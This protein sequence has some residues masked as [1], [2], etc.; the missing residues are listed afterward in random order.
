M[1]TG[2]DVVGQVSRRDNLGWYT[3]GALAVDPTVRLE[4]LAPPCVFRLRRSLSLNEHASTL[5]PPTHAWRAYRRAS[6]AEGWVTPCLR[7]RRGGG[8]GGTADR[9]QNVGVAT[10]LR[11]RCLCARPSCTPAHRDPRRSQTTEHL[12]A[13]Q[14]LVRYL[15]A[16]QRLVVPEAAVQL[17]HHTAPMPADCHIV[18]NFGARLAAN[19][20]LAGLQEFGRRWTT[21]ER[22]NRPRMMSQLWRVQFYNMRADDD[23]VH[24]Q[25]PGVSHILLRRVLN[26]G[27][28]CVLR[29]TN[30]YVVDDE[31][32]L[33]TWVATRDRRA[34]I[35]GHLP[36]LRGARLQADRPVTTH[37][38]R[39]AR[40][41]RRR[42]RATR[43]WCAT[44]SG[45]RRRTAFGA[46]TSARRAA[47]CPSR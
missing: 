16:Q 12:E 32:F 44:R 5:P 6:R 11:H 24:V 36:F 2:R 17:G 10:Q 39:Q 47:S 18:H 40:C 37:G 15:V 1:P 22:H 29:L 41:L 33:R 21:N 7:T 19:S 30:A 14:G 3:N 20:V 4:A 38:G 8:G 25:T 27:R 23:G 9:N 35:R 31:E 45:G 34:L 46:F 28:T 13:V 42:R 43:R 26:R